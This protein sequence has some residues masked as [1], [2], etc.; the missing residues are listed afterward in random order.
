MKR[1]VLLFCALLLALL[2]ACRPEPEECL[3]QLKDSAFLDM[4]AEFLKE[5][6]SLSPDCPCMVL[7]DIQ[8]KACY[9]W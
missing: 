9:D 3:A 2:A 8:N 1:L 4:Y 7:L 5:Q 6:K